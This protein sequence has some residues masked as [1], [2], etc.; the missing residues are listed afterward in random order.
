MHITLA[1]S[2]SFAAG[3][4][5]RG[6]VDSSSVI[7]APPPKSILGVFEIIFQ[8]SGGIVPSGVEDGCHVAV[9]ADEAVGDAGAGGWDECLLLLV[10]VSL[11][12]VGQGRGV[13]VGS[14]TLGGSEEDR[15]RAVDDS[16][17]FLLYG[18][19]DVLIWPRVLNSWRRWWSRWPMDPFPSVVDD[20]EGLCF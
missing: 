17:S 6:V 3:I 20:V 9:V 12:G 4:F 15:F 14:H 11:L 1:S 13:G 5:E 19:C 10:L 18:R 7:G 16:A 8:S 2:T